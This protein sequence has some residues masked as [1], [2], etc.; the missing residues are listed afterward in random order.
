MVKNKGKIKNFP[1]TVDTRGSKN[2]VVL[3][4]GK[5]KGS[6]LVGREGEK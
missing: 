5:G 1:K 2:M 6:F 3:S 4:Q